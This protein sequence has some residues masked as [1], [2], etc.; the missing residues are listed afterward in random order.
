M[1]NPL[2]ELIPEPFY[3]ITVFILFGVLTLALAK[4]MDR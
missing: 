3:T 1:I 4:F 2:S